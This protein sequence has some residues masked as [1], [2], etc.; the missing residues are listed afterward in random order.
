[1]VNATLSPTISP[2]YCT[3]TGSRSRR[4]LLSHLTIHCSLDGACQSPTISSSHCTL[5]GSR[6]RR[7]LLSHL[8][9]HC[10]AN[11]ACHYP[12]ISPSYCTLTGALCTIIP[13]YQSLLSRW[14]MPISHHFFVPL[15]A[16]RQLQPC[17]VIPPYRTRQI[18]VSLSRPP[19]WSTNR[20]FRVRAPG[21][22]ANEKN[23]A[24]PLSLS[25]WMPYKETTAG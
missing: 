5:T 14:C 23:R 20:C 9:I 17:T 10:S 18:S 13:P 12:T 21:W 16:Y 7:A 2:S 11:G 4:A 25:E 1:M 8:T 15:H 19:R 6:S 3:L 24:P 22:Y